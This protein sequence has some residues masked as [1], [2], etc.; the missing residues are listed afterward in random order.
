MFVTADNGEG[1]AQGIERI[2]DP[3]PGVGQ[4]W[5]RGTQQ[6]DSATAAPPGM[7]P[8]LLSEEAAHSCAPAQTR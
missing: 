5:S 1:T 2:N 8:E 7:L 6:V 3:P 4:T